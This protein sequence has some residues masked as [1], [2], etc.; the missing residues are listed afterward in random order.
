MRVAVFSD[1]HGNAIALA[2]VLADIEREGG[3]DACWVIGDVADMGSD[4][5][6]CIR[7]LRGLDNLV[8]IR[9]NADRAV[10]ESGL[11]SGRARELAAIRKSSDEDAL[12]AL[13]CLED[14][15]WT[16]AVITQAGLD[17]LDWLKGLPLEARQSLPDGTRVLLV[18]AAPGRDDGPGPLP[19]ASDDEL[20]AMLAGCDADLVIVG[21]THTP[22]DRTVDGIRVIN[23]GSVSNPPMA[24]KR[25]KWLLLEADGSSGYR[26]ER[27]LV[28]YD[29]DA[30]LQA[31]VDIE[32]P[33]RT[34]IWQHFGRELVES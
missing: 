25:A 26:I 31:L 32:H 27:H 1:C 7:L 24:D 18:H 6:G 21:H 29:R 10:S 15:A 23:S 12:I 22:L 14:A 20:R 30:Y 19:S 34:R 28:A 2:A 13:R 8:V 33:A 9:G 3:A 16:R 17:H 11:A 5:V 4:P